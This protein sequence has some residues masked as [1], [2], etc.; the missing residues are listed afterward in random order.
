MWDTLQ[1]IY[2]VGF[3]VAFAITSFFILLGGDSL[4][5]GLIKIPLYSFLWPIVF[6]LFVVDLVT[7][8]FNLRK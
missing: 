3:I 4:K 6:L 1:I 8:L 7:D 5:S 2:W